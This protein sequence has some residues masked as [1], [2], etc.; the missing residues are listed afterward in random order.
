M[1]PL[2]FMLAMCVSCASLIGTHAQPIPSKLPCRIYIENDE[3]SSHVQ[4]IAI[5]QTKGYAYI[6]FTTSLVKYDMN[7]QTIVG[8]VKGLTCHLGCMDLDPE[9]GKLYT[10]VEYKDDA[11]GKGIYKIMG[12]ELGKRENTFYIGIFD[13]EKIN[14]K[15]IDAEK[16]GV[17]TTVYLPEVVQFYED[18]IMHKGVRT[19]HRYGCSGIDGI[20]LGPQFGKTDGKKIL[21][22]DVAI[23]GDTKRTDND[24][25]MLLQFD[26]K[27]LDKYAIPLNQSAPHHSGPKK[28]DKRFFVFT[29]NTTYGIQNLEYDAYT[30]YW[31]A[32]VYK[33]SK[34]QYPNYSLFAIDGT[35]KGCKQI[36]K[37]FEK[38]EKG[39]VVPLAKAGN[40]HAASDTYGWTF[41]AS[42]GI[43]SLGNGYFYISKG[44]KNKDG[45]QTCD[46]RLYHF[47]GN[48]DKPF[49]E[50]D[51]H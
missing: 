1:N 5:D 6:S 30:K 33:G 44:G 3:P 18:T 51:N 7:K 36:L 45:M 19:P 24:Y 47:T 41:D 9:T 20:S 31:F 29:G 37:G 14:R 16:G 39:I 34:P 35:K 13:T 10:S 27:K 22:V 28:A 17:M 4:G 15:G 50:V 2:K 26:P 49:E 40:H 11:I 38:V 43:E 8:S 46:M 12:K 21:L 32:A 48:H 23:Y 25:Q 42:T